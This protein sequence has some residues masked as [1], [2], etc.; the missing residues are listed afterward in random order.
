MKKTITTIALTLALGLA[1]VQA[2]DARWGKGWAGDAASPCGGPGCAQSGEV[3]DFEA[4]EQFFTDTKDLRE[5]LFTKKSE[6]LEL[7]NQEDPDKEL[8]K[9]LWSELFDIKQEL[10][11][12]AV[13]AG[14][15]P[16]AGPGGFGPGPAFR[17]GRGCGGPKGNFGCNG[18][19]CATGSAP[20]SE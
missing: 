6:Y 15:N 4:M 18:S 1:A 11:A 16:N 3:A 9:E 2:S 10:Q 20:V 7:V 17:G 5:K 19:G 12:K 8:A 13:S 14:I